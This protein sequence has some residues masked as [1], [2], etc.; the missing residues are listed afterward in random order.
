MRHI[1]FLFVFL[2]VSASFAQDFFETAE[3]G[4]AA[5]LP[6][7]LNGFMRGAFFAG[8]GIDS[9]EL[10]Q[11]SGYGELGVKMRVRKEKW[12]DGYAELRFRRGYEFDQSLSEFHLREA[13]INT[14]LGHLDVRM[15][16]QIVVWGRADGFNPTN[17][18]TPQD[19]TTRSSVED[20]RRLGNFLFRGSYNFRPFSLELIWVPQYRPSVLPTMLFPF[21]ESVTLGVADNPSADLKNSSIAAKLDLALSSVDGSISYFSGFMPLP[22]VFLHPDSCHIS[23]GFRA[24]VVNK[25]YQMH[26]FGGDFSTT[27]GDFG[28]RG[29]VAY[30]QPIDD[31]EDPLNTHVPRPDLQYVFGIDKTIGDFSIIV[32]YI[33]RTVFEFAEF[34]STGLPTDQLYL[35]NRMITGQ[36]DPTSHA[37]FMR[38]ALALM[39]ETLDLELLAYYNVTT[40]EALLRPLV[41][42]DITDAMTVKLGGDFYS[43]PENTLFGN[44]DKALSSVFIELGV[45]F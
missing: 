42:Y 1:C 43:G 7:E 28:L 13:Y 44:I 3:A 25:P 22:G 14:Y 12:G 21:P 37:A 31:F 19:M 41:A 38:P 8:I 4:D 35:T 6:Y 16:Q 33:G 10:V 45:S 40:E 26:V 23:G 24:T 27:I 11:K 2:I 20:D 39:H 17:N 15:G 30:R 34:D 18:I 9:D 29:E 5:S 36:L 32:Q